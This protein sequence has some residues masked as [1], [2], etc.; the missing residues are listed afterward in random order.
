MSWRFLAERLLWMVIVL[1]G[2]TI[3]VFVLTHVVPADPARAAAGPEASEEHVQALRRQM[4]LDRPLPVQYFSYMRDLLSLNFGRSIQTQ[5]YVKEDLAV[6]FPATAELALGVMLVY[7]VLSVILGV[8]AALRSGGPVD[9]A[10]RFIA[11]VGVGFPAFWLAMLLQ[12][13][14]YRDLQWLPAAGRLDP[15][16]LAPARL[17]GLYI[18]DSLATGNWAALRS[19]SAHLVLPVTAAVMARMAVGLKLTRVSVL[20]VLGQDYIRT[21][22]SKGLAG[23]V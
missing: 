14:F 23:A 11:T 3:L 4:G 2:I 19:A 6:Y 18:I 8:L 1:C 22:R 10:L 17:T 21:A 7:T 13:V 16:V 15:T 9:Y 5:R 20:E 12:M